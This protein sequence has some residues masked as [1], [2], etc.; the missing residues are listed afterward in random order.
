MPQHDIPI[1]GRFDVATMPRVNIALKPLPAF[2]QIQ[3]RGRTQQRVRHR[4]MPHVLDRL[5]EPEQHERTV[6]VVDIGQ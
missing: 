3:G 1:A 5:P 6:T 4:F 2:Q